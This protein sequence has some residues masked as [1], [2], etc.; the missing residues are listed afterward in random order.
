MHLLL[1]CGD[2]K[3]S[4]RD[5]VLTLQFTSMGHDIIYSCIQ[6]VHV[7][8]GVIIT[9]LCQAQ[10]HTKECKLE[11]CEETGM[12]VGQAEMLGKKGCKKGPITS[13][14]CHAI[15]IMSGWDCN[16]TVSGKHP[17]VRT[18]SS[19]Q[20]QTSKLSDQWKPVNVPKFQM[21]PRSHVCFPDCV[22][23]LA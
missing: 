23:M 8:N 20:Q 4:S 1:D 19:N 11:L 7:V 16:F 15:L 10:S 14:V 18:L 6:H 3:L 17:I 22:I 5:L 13:S 9:I 12:A 21:W 2:V